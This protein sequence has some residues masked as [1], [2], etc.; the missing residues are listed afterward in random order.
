[1]IENAFYK[2]DGAGSDC[3][4]RPND[5]KTDTACKNNVAYSRGMSF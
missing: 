2:I 1:M 5:E 3:Y 4:R